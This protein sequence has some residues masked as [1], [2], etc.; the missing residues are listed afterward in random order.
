M[1][2]E[3]QSG[4]SRRFWRRRLGDVRAG[5]VTRAL[6][7]FSVFQHNKSRVQVTATRPRG[8]SPRAAAGLLEPVL[9]SP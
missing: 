2:T 3:S 6:C 8:D 7:L 1:G 4:K 9:G 5:M